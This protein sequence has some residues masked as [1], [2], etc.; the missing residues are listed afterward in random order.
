MYAATLEYRFP[1]AK[2]VQGVV[3]TDMGSTWGLM[4]ERFRGIRMTTLL[5]S[6]WVSGFV[7]RRLSSRSA[8]IM[9]M[10]TEISS[11][12]VSEHS[13]NHRIRR[14]NDSFFTETSSCAGRRGAARMLCFSVA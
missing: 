8:L 11:T 5:I 6:L 4:K 10:V 9:G 14:E 2:K 7:F 13:F 12:L 1:I 3:F